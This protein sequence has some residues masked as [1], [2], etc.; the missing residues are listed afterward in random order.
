M[1]AAL[2]V[3]FS[4]ALLAG[5]T[6]AVVD[7]SG[8]SGPVITL[9][10]ATSDLAGGPQAS[11][12]EHF[13][14]AVADQSEGR[15]RVQTIYG[16]EEHAQ[17]FD[18]EVAR[19][20]QDGTYDFGIVPARSWDDLGVDGLRALQTPF[21]LDSD[22]LVDRI[23]DGELASRC[24]TS[25]TAPASVASHSGRRRSAIPSGSAHPCSPSLSSA[26]HASKRR[27]HAT[28]T[29]SSERSVVIRCGWIS[30]ASTPGTP[31]EP[32]PEPKPAPT[33]RS[34]HRRPSRPT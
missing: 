19:R 32:W 21:L 23:V 17:K 2:V 18:Q 8:G 3:L 10:L 30:R 7:K 16:A 31:R 24:S 25:S 22:D 9:S 14:D 27:T 15:L 29:P 13:A 28:S 5:C 33:E 1:R 12:L 4:A 26:V 11:P 6:Q 34:G 20:I